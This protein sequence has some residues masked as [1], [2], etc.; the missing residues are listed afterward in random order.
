MAWQELKLIFPGAVRINRGGQV[1]TE[2]MEAARA[3]GYSDVVMLHEHRGEPGA[4]T[5][6][7]YRLAA[8]VHNSVSHPICSMFLHCGGA[9]IMARKKSITRFRPSLPLR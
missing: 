4:S 6:L 9:G 8:V 1:L 7:A 3:G 2:L 5:Q